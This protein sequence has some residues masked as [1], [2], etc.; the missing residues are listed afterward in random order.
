MRTVCTA[1]LS[2]LVLLFFTKCTESSTDSCPAAVTRDQ[3][4]QEYGDYCLEFVHTERNWD[5]ARKDCNKRS[6]NLVQV[7][8]QDIQD[9]IVKTLRDV[10][11]WDRHGVW[12]GATDKDVEQK[13]MWVTGQELTWSNWQPGE[14]PQ[15]TD[16]FLFVPSHHSEDCA[17][18]RLDDPLGR[19][20][21]YRCDGV[22][23]HYSYI[24]QYFKVNV[25]TQVPQTVGLPSTDPPATIQSFQTTNGIGAQTDSVTTDTSATTDV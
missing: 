21:D 16:G 11:H 5:D 1:V 8:N 19:W 23:I 25:H 15:H 14:G 4:L 17:Q 22:G 20:H 7:V 10:L 24:C 12:I 13:W 18:I 2:I 9:F 6:G 3:H